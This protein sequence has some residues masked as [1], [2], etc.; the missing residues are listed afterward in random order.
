MS[1]QIR[2]AFVQCMKIHNISY[3]MSGKVQTE[4][5]GSYGEWI[6]E[7]KVKWWWEKGNDTE[8]WTCVVQADLKNKKQV[9]MYALN[10]W[11]M[12]WTGDIRVEEMRNAHR[13]LVENLKG[14]D[15]SGALGVNG[16]I[17]LKCSLQNYNILTYSGLAWLIIMGSGFDDLVYWLFF[18]ITVNY[19]S[20]W[21]MR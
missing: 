19:N 2:N 11:A 17:L 3:Q 7:M 5:A 1:R 13:S 16:R 10:M 21:G 15:K 20:S 14:W 4:M 18:T 9:S 6:T 8:E 12:G